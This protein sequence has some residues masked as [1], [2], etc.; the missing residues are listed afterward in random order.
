MKGRESFEGKKIGVIMGGTSGEREVSLRSGKK[1]HESLLRQGFDAVALDVRDDAVD[2]I[3]NGGFDIAFIILHGRGGEDGTIQGVLEQ[4][5]IPYTG[6]GVLAS[7]LSM[8]KVVSKKLFLHEGI[9]TPEYLVLEREWEAEKAAREA[10]ALLKYPM[11]LKPVDEG[12]SLGVVI[13]HGREEFLESLDA[14]RDH[15]KGLFV[16]RYISG[17]CVTVGI[18]GTGRSARPLPVLELVPSK[19]FYD[20][21]AKYTSGM[22]EFICPARLNE[23]VYAETQMHATRAHRVLGI[24][25]FSR[26]DMQIDTSGRPYVLEVNSIPGMTELSDLPA[27]ARAFGMS[28]DDL[29]FEILKSSLEK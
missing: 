6:S 27:E 8:D 21:E 11:V 4:L 13:V 26:V 9:P 12:S 25:G 1:V 24:V 14:E 7:A 2:V 23:R 20:Y 3:K 16:E 22:T 29:V 10:E 17:K 28:Y 15:Y 18:L 5:K 19:E